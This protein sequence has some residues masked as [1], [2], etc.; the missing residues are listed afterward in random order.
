MKKGD[1]V[2]FKDPCEGENDLQMFL[3]EDPD[4]DRVLVVSIVPG[5]AIQPTAVVR[6][7][8]LVCAS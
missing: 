8:D 3:A 1:F 4:G 5:W 7:E 2:K 6:T